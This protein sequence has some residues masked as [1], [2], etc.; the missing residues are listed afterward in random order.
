MTAPLIGL[1]ARKR[2]GKDTVAAFLR[3]EMG[4][5]RVAFADP[6]RQA[7]LE[8]DPIVS[9]WSPTR[10]SDVIEEHGWDGYKESPYGEEIR[11]LMQRFG[12]ESIRALDD[13]FW[14]RT[15]MRKA[16]DLIEGGLL[17]SIDGEIW[18]PER[19][20]QPVVIT[21]CRFPNEAEAIVNAGGALVVIER[22]GLP[23]NDTHASE[24]AWREIVPD[25]VI[26][27]DGTLDELRQ[28]AVKVAAY[29]ANRDHL[30]A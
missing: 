25:Y 27:N 29:V 13:G 17:T 24:N 1:M 16:V 9:A 23:D 30:Y 18:E 2:A 7:L 6:M 26:H 12:T 5:V 10:L 22:P 20:P 14:V 19:E 8:L 11:S 4:Y 21:D 28:K 15:A 3:E